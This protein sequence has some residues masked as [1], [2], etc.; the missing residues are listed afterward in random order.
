MLYRYATAALAGQERV[1]ITHTQGRGGVFRLSTIIH[2]GWKRTPNIETGL[3]LQQPLRNASRIVEIKFRRVDVV[4]LELGRIL[5]TQV[6][7]FAVLDPGPR[8]LMLG[9]MIS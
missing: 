6:L 1:G 9:S 7:K 8:G 5:C 3:Q 2:K 4:D